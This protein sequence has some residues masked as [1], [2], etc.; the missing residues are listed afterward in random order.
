MADVTRPRGP[1]DIMVVAFEDRAS[2]AVADAVGDL[3]DKDVIRILDLLYVEKADDGV[4]SVLET[5]ADADG[6]DLL[7][8]PADLPGLLAEEDALAVAEALDNGTAAAVL[9]WENTWAVRTADA[10]A[11]SGGSVVAHE[12]IPSSD[13]AAV[14]DALTG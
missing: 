14:L 3:V 8:F 5:D 2:S 9:A 1:V 6:V 13:V 11:A 10:I 12:R 4:V 7:G